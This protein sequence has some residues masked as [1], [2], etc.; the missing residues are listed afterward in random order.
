MIGLHFFNHVVTG[1]RQIIAGSALLDLGIHCLVAV[2]G[3]DVDVITSFFLELR[4]KG[5]IDVVPPIIEVEDLV[6]GMRSHGDR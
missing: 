1:N 5:W 6:A 4:Q 3:F 2:E